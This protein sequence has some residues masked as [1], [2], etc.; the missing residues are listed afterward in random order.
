[1]RPA[2]VKGVVAPRTDL[3]IVTEEGLSVAGRVVDEARNP[4]AGVLVTAKSEGVWG[5]ETTT[6]AGGAFVVSGLAPGAAEVHAVDDNGTAGGYLPVKIETAAGTEGLE[7]V[8]RKGLEISG[9]IVDEDG[10]PVVGREVIARDV[11]TN[12]FDAA[13]VRGPLTDAEGRFRI[14]AIAPGTYRLCLDGQGGGWVR[15]WLTGG[16]SVAAGKTDLALKLTSG[17]TISGEAVDAS[18]APV[19]NEQV[20]AHWT[21]D[22]WPGRS[23]FTDERGRFEIRGLPLGRSYTL[24]VR[25]TVV[26]DVALGARD[27]RIEAPAT[28]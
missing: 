12:P 24:R 8:L 18:G 5:A 17:G 7:I 10:R 23:A 21:P 16:E 19:K 22:A 25:R 28:K 11:A 9:R 1:M 6:D 13:V 26:R 27:L 4:V 2:T 15:M 20:S 14:G 3:A